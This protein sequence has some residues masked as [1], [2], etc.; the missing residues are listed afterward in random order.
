MEHLRYCVVCS[1]ANASAIRRGQELNALGDLEGMPP[2]RRDQFYAE[3]LELYCA[4]G[5][6]LVL[7]LGMAALGEVV[8]R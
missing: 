5:Q 8:N 4:H 1:L 3:T 6:R 7:A 2:D